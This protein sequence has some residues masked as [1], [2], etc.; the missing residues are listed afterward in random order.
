MDEIIKDNGAR[1][2]LL[3]P[4][5]WEDLKFHKINN[6]FGLHFT[7]DGTCED[8]DFEVLTQDAELKVPIR[9]TLE[10]ED[11]DVRACELR[12]WLRQR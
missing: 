11:Y 1:E 8:F 7:I 6:L 9:F 5:I 3:D 10:G 4:V 2:N 12:D